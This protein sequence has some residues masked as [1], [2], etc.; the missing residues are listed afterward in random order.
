[1]LK[2]FSVGLRAGKKCAG[3]GADESF[4]KSTYNPEAAYCNT[5]YD[6]NPSTLFYDGWR[7]AMPIGIWGDPGQYS[8]EP[9]P[10][11]VPLYYAAS[12]DYA[13]FG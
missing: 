7:P 5:G 10:G 1:V 9:S 11:Q 13:L 3:C 12:G 2:H 6:K 8:L 4:P